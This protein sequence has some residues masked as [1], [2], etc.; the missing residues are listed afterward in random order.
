M[1][2]VRIVILRTS[3]N[4]SIV[5]K[6]TPYPM[7]I[8]L[9][10]TLPTDLRGGT[11][12]H[13]SK[14]KSKSKSKS[15]SHKGHRH[16]SRSCREHHSSKHVHTIGSRAQVMHDHACHTSGGLEKE[17]LRR[18]KYGE[19]VS[20]KKSKLGKQLYRQNKDEMAPPFTKS[21]KR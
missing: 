2:G 4:K 9:P 16:R 5:Y 6:H 10:S 1:R 13:R 21:S 15:T 20:I 14:S 19:I 8:V 12:T 7:E 11:H 17:E 3:P 18:N